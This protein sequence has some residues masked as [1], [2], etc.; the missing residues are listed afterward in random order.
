[1]SCAVAAELPGV[2]EAGEKVAVAPVGKPVAEKVTGFEY[3]P[4]CGV[5]VMEYCAEPPACTVCAVV[6]EVMVNV[7]GGGTVPVPV[8]LTLCGEPE[9]LS[10]TESVAVK[11][12]AEA[13]VKVMEMEQ[14]ALAARVSP[15]VL[16]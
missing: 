12:A 9:A 7:G 3:A 11:L 13:G 14:V 4:F 10:A 8:R 1:M 16:V 15:Q 2:S 6:D 5:T